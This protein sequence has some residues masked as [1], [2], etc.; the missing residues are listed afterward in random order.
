MLCEMQCQEFMKTAKGDP[1]YDVGPCKTKCSA[2]LASGGGGCDLLKYQ[3]VCGSDKETYASECALA[4][5]DLDGCYPV[6]K[7]A[8]SA[9]CQPAKLTK[10][11]EGECYDAVKAPE[12]KDECNPVCG[13]LK[14]GKA[15]SFANS[16]LAGKAGASV[17]VCDGISATKNDVCSASLYKAKGCC[18]S[19]DYSVVNQICASKTVGATSQWVTFRNQGEYDCLTKG[20][21][22]WVIQYKGPCI[23][24][25]TNDSKPVCGADG[26]TYTNGCQAECY[27]PGGQFNYA[28][29]ACK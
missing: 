8:K 15:Q 23:C 26:Q 10:L 5:C 29:G 24:Q 2:P 9:T 16:C 14:G 27:N 25:C 22:G 17:G 12:C 6:G 13:I 7:T 4:H 21:A 3:P 11:C 1:K 19:V 20:D 28:P 18:P